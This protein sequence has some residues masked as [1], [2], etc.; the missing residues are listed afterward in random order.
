MSK[1]YNFNQKYL[2][3]KCKSKYEIPWVSING[4]AFSSGIFGTSPSL[5][6]IWQSSMSIIRATSVPRIWTCRSISTPIA[7]SI[8]RGIS[9]SS[10]RAVPISFVI[11][12]PNCILHRNNS[13]HELTVLKVENTKSE[14]WAQKFNSGNPIAYTSAGYNKSITFFPFMFWERVQQLM[15]SWQR[16][17]P[18]MGRF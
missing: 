7:S 9:T 16:D 6:R 11:I 13:V 10:I 17:K 2:N 4:R 15:E 8:R 3:M 5:L 14:T 1:R 12:I 18:H